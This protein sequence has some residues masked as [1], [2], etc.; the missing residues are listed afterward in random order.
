MNIITMKPGSPEWVRSYSASKAAAMLGISSYQTRSDLMHMMFT[1]VAPDVSART[2]GIFDNG[3]RVEA[4]ARP[5]VEEIIGDTLYPVAGEKDFQMSRPLTMSSDGATDNFMRSWENKQPNAALIESLKAGVLPDEYQPQCQQIMM[6]MGCYDV[7]FTVSDG[8]KILASICV[9]PSHAWAKRILDGWKQF[10]IDFANYAPPEVMPLTVAQPAM[11]L[12]AVSAQVTGIVT[13][14]DNFTAY[15]AALDDFLANKLIRK[16]ATDQDFADLE[17]QIK[18]LK[19]AEE[20]LDSAEMQILSQVEAVDLAKRTKDMLHKLTRDNR[21]MAEK[22]L[23]TRKDQI[24]AEIIASGQ[25]SLQAFVDSLN[26]VIGKPLMPLIRADFAGAVKGRRTVDSLREAVNNELVRCKIEGN[27]IAGKISINLATLRETAK[28][29]IFL[30]A[31][32]PQIVLKSPDDLTILVKSRI[33]DH[34]AGEEKRLD[35][36]RARIRQEE[37][38]RVRVIVP[39]PNISTVNQTPIKP[40][41]KPPL[42]DKA[43]PT[44]GGVVKLVAESFRVSESVASMWLAGMD[45]NKNR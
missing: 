25:A 20:M 17:A 32:T 40:T 37:E 15:G 9:D 42:T 24:R 19:K 6:V 28:D 8:E 13:I 4:L 38:A 36:E 12:P 11:L 14:R 22:L 1:G 10:D 30:F 5:L 23:S 18:A 44:A 2:Q 45:F 21:L 35:G 27:D 26:E 31:D 29:F 39:V 34:V 16:P 7:F 43:M 41:D 33:T 3:H